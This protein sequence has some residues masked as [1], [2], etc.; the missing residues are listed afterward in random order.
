MPEKSDSLF[1]RVVSILEEARSNVVRAVNSNMVL[2]YWLIGREIV[3]E[4][5]SGVNRANYGKKVIYNLSTE[6]TSKIG[7]GFSTTNLRYFRKFYQVYSR[8]APEI[9]HIGCGESETSSKRH[10]RCGVLDDLSEALETEMIRGFSPNL[11]WSHYRA[12]MD[13]ENENERLF[14]EIE[15]EKENWDVKHLNRQIHSFLFARLFKSKNKEGVLELAREGQNPEEAEDIIKNPYILDFLGIPD[16]KVFHESELEAAIISNLQDFMLELGKGF[17][18][19]GRQK[20]MQFDDKYFYIDLVFYN[21]IL[22]CYLLIDLKIGE[23]THQDIGQMDGYVHMFEEQYRQE[24]DNPTI[25][26]ILCSKKQKAIAKYSVLNE[27]KQLF[28]S[29]YMLYLPS[30]EELKLEIEKERKLLEEL[31]G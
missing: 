5:Q 7:R 29:K 16:T 17:A 20:R 13:V 12:L 9:R 19:V 15:A 28:A 23:L 6:L 26:L 3:E 21:C 31:G 22:K 27:S 30:E 2:A 11:G 24:S 10:I 4:I 25:G 8:R 14:Y 1:N 18:F